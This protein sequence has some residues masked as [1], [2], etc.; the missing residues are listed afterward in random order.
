MNLKA[1]QSIKRLLVRSTN[2]IGDA[3][4]T[5]PAVRA[6][7]RNFPD[8]R[9][10]LL[11]KPWVAPVFAHSPH[12]DEIIVYDAMGRHRGALGPLRLARDLHRQGFDAAI[13]LQNA[14]E[15]AL[16]AF[17]A[18]IPVRIGF[19]TD[20]RRL[21]L[22]HPVRCTKAIKAIHQTGYY[23]KIL[24]GVG[25]A[26]WE[27]SLEL[28][29]GEADRRQALRILASH[30]IE[31]GRP[32]IGLNPSATFGPAKQWFPERY[33]ALGERLH[34]R[35]DAAIVI[36]GGPADRDLGQSITG[37]MACPVID[38]SGRTSLGEAMA[39]IDRC[40]AFVTNDSGLM[41]VAAALDTPLVAIFG[42]TNSTTTSPYSPTSRIV[43]VS[44]ECSPCMQ[45]VCPLGHMNCMR[46]VSVDMV[47]AAVEGLL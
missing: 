22:T 44:I 11:A 10:S 31:G 7:R 23:L 20:A 8:A 13:L 47:S 42:S 21:L 41:H 46:E 38:L 33:A 4:M 5:T 37:M 9:I 6:I 45:P 43:R 24:E 19:D 15:A 36:F 18:R 28:H 14:I 30:G 27:Q 32:L 2:W 39:L 35:Y 26:T 17:M 1:R 3:V 34:R 25:L 40:S 29:L 12:V 16:I